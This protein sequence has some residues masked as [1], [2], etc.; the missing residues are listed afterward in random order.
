[1][2][3]YTSIWVLQLTLLLII[4]TFAF[5]PTLCPLVP[6]PKGRDRDQRA[7]AKVTMAKLACYIIY[8]LLPLQSL[9]SFS[10]EKAKGQWKQRSSKKENNS[11]NN[12][13]HLCRIVRR[14]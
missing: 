14:G 9:P 12:L 4:T 10:S 13:C 2:E 5:V 8:L 11:Y 1:M 6:C 3:I 7:K